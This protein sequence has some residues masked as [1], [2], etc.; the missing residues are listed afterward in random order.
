MAMT[1]EAA[2]HLATALDDVATALHA[3]KEEERDSV[4]EVI[5]LATRLARVA[6]KLDMQLT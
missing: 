6:A 1:K 5:L 4:L 3:A 2:K